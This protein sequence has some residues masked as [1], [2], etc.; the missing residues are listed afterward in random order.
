MGA[1]ALC[2]DGMSPSAVCPDLFAR[3]H[4]LALCRQQRGKLGIRT[5]K[6]ILN[7]VQGMLFPCAEA[8]RTFLPRTAAA[9]VRG[10]GAEN[11]DG[12]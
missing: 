12:A 6:P 7:R 9:G 8:H 2:L 3:R 10:S 11:A 5:G 1:A 4:I